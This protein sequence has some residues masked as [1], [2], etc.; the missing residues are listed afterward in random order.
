MTIVHPEPR[1][2]AAARPS[3]RSI[4]LAAALFG[5]AAAMA[6]LASAPQGVETGLAAPAASAWSVGGL[7]PFAR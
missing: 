2:A 7:D 6:V 3:A 5:L 4:L 1:R